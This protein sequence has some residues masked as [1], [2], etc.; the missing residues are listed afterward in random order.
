MSV[1][2]DSVRSLF[3]KDVQKT[4]GSGY[5]EQKKIT[6]RLLLCYEVNVIHING[7]IINDKLP[8]IL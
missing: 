4:I 8:I 2:S 3:L 5:H 7:E 6:N 1:R